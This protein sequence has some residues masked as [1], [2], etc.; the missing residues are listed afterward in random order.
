MCVCVFVAWIVHGLQQTD[1]LLTLNLLHVYFTIF[2][3]F[4]IIAKDSFSQQ[5][6]RTV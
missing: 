3:L 1:L 5:R 2:V 6:R 4:N